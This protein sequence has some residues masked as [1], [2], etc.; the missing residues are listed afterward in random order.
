MLDQVVPE[1][2]PGD[3]ICSL[4]VWFHVLAPMLAAIGDSLTDSFNNFFIVKIIPWDHGD[5]RDFLL[6]FIV[7]PESKTG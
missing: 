3:V 1:C 2:N 6:V 5:P 4:T 7:H